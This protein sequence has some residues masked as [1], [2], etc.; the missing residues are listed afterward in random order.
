MY[1]GYVKRATAL[2]LFLLAASFGLAQKRTPIV[3]W[4]QA[5]NLDSKGIEAV[6]HEFERRHPEYEVKLSS[7][8][9]GEMNPQKLLTS[10]VGN[11]APDAVKQ[12]RFTLS[13]W[14]SRNAFRPL[15]DLIERDRKVDPQ[16]PTSEQYYPATWKETV[17]E[18]R[19]YGIPIAAD[20]RIL[21]YNKDIFK[22]KAA[23]LRAAGLDPD[24]P[25][26]TWSEL[27]AYSK[28][29]TERNPDGTLKLAG[30]IPNFGNTWLY[31]YAFQTNAS[32]M[33]ADGRRCTLYTPD[34][35]EALEFM[36]RGYE[37]LG[38][39][40]NAQNFQAGF[41]QNENDA[42][43]VGKVAMKVDGDWIINGLSRYAGRMDFA[44]APA[45]VP[46]D[47]Y[48]KHGKYANEKDAFI[49]WTGGFAYSIPRG[50]RNVEGAWAFIKFATS[51]EGRRIEHQGQRESERRRGRVYTPRL[52][53][54]IEG[55]RIIE[56]EFIPA[57]P[58]IAAA[59]R[60]HIRMLPYGKLRPATF[61]G[62]TLWDE[63]V[64]A[65]EDACRGTKSV[66]QALKDGQAKV[67]SEL[68]AYFD[69]ER[70]PVVDLA[71]PTYI[72]IGLL[73]LGAVAIAIWLRRLRLGR[74]AKTEARWGFL[75]ISPW[76]FGFLALTLGP[77][78]ASLFFSFTQY[79]V[80]SEPRFVGLNNYATIGG[81]DAGVTKTVL[82]N[83]A[84]IGGI[85]VPLGIVTGLSVALLLNSAVRGLRFYRTMFYMPAIVPIVATAVLWIWILNADPNKGLLNAL[86]RSTLGS[87]FNLAPPG[88]LTMPEYAKMSLIIMGVWGAGGGMLLWLAG[89]K[90]I[91]N[92]LYE[93]ASID[94]ASPKQQ[95][96]KITL[97][98]LSPI[99]FFN[100]VTGFIGSLQE[101]DKAYIV[102][103]GN[104][105]GPSDSLLTPVLHLF[106]N[107][108]RYFKMGYA[109][110]I[111]WFIF[112][113][114]LLLTLLQFR[115]APKWV[116]YEANG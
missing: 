71:V 30:F 32:F 65:F 106:N 15:D 72:G 105:G 51:P 73:A 4:G 77:M 86:W 40:S 14:A 114:I 111:A 25:P 24:R 89:L 49:T 63:H 39:Y 1:A 98:Q 103:T 104:T 83:I 23:D 22:R 35:V 109:S 9:A 27:L 79:N 10:I 69:R 12:D 58:R 99:I 66:E 82:L 16:T 94:G 36:K 90:G 80:L 29:L 38:G 6:V 3:I 75:F 112:I 84:Y 28:A 70:Y 100:L 45:P 17:F 88:W 5:L 50:A 37:D 46:D 64:R 78:L 61:V 76:V 53:A 2:L 42:F 44:V 21:Y 81:A 108:F 110:S 57:D 101:F 34:S 60:E 93:A 33:S 107:G 92:Q 20:D 116:H 85:G 55:N 48:A 26:R 18:G 31:L 96:F 11:V 43:V 68:D 102:S 54:S 95:L 52:A 8:G 47:R 19:T 41:Q 67:Q 62:Q 115:L 13:D 113:V 56:Q 91:P 87:W 7:M 59:L 97:P 74:M